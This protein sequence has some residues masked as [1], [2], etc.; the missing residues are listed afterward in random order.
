MLCIIL[1]G[2][3]LLHI[4][5]STINLPVK[6]SKQIENSLNSCT[7]KKSVYI[8]IPCKPSNSDNTKVSL[9][10]EIKRMTKHQMRDN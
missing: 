5:Y 2:I 10:E 8:A 7:F 6:A 3:L 9:R 4:Y 1:Y